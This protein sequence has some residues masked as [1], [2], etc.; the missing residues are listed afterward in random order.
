METAKKARVVTAKD[1]DYCRLG[2]DW[3]EDEARDLL[4]L[5]QQQGHV[6]K[7]KKTL[8]P[9]KSTVLK[10]RLQEGIKHPTS[11]TETLWVQGPCSEKG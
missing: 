2:G 3:Q 7:V 6:A 8:A 5:L 10:G 9:Q 1:A 11:P 4:L